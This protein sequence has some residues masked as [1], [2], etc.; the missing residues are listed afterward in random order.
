MVVTT[1]YEETNATTAFE[2]SHY[3]YRILAASILCLMTVVGVVGNSLVI[4]AVYFS[5][6]LQTTTNVF[7]ACLAVTDLLN[8]LFFPVQV[9]SVLT[10]N[11]PPPIGS[12]CAIAGGIIIT[13][14][15]TSIVLL[16]M[17]AL[18]RW[19][20]ITR[21]HHTYT[22]VYT[23]RNLVLMVIISWIY[24]LIS[25]IIPQ[26]AGQGSLGYSKRY[27]TCVWSDEQ[28]DDFF[29]PM[30]FSFSV[31]SAFV[32]ITSSYVSIAFHVRRQARRIAVT[33][34]NPTKA[35]RQNNQN[36]V[37]TT[38]LP[39]ISTLNTGALQ[40]VEPQQHANPWN[41]REIRVTKNL[42]TV[43]CVFYVL[44][45]P[46]GVCSIVPDSYIPF[47][48]FSILILS[49][50][51]VNPIIYA[52]KHPVFSQVFIYIF[53]CRLDSLPEPSRGLRYILRHR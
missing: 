38:G 40:I 7:V 30:V 15:V 37:S 6:K 17:I 16:T 52:F 12:L 1:A 31:M 24:P 36:D 50:S 35:S 49:N 42:A 39:P 2:F 8:C 51:I 43:V 25:M 20:K 18:N 45:L 48:C 21:S 47:I 22:R 10:R 27:K 19:I 29:M 11:G 53:K 46:Y 28:Q 32:V 3:G 41:A 14:N 44:V 26:I 23:R 34:S 4:I 13:T 5:N 33:R 9:V